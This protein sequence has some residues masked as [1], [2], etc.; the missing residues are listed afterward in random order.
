MFGRESYLSALM[1]QNRKGGVI[2]MGGTAGATTS[3]NFMVGLKDGLQKYP[4]LKL[5]NE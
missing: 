2:F 5:L 3:Q 4:E 1:R